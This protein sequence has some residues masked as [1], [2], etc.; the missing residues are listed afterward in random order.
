LAEYGY[1]TYLMDGASG[2]VSK[3][4]FQANLG[5][6]VWPDEFGNSIVYLNDKYAP[7]VECGKPVIYLYPEKDM[8]VSV[9]VGAN[10][11]KSE[12]IYAG[13]WS[14]LARKNGEL[15]LNGTT[16]PYLFWEGKGLGV[17]P[18]IKN[19]T[20]VKQ[21]ETASTI[22]KQLAEM[23]L[24]SK[25]IA[26]FNEFWLPKLPKAPFVRLTWL[27]NQEMNELAPL[28]VEPKPDS[29]LRVFLDFEGLNQSTSIPAQI[30]P[31]YE[32]KGFTLVEWG[33]LLKGDR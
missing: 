32:R 11:R 26:D 2:K 15:V 24:N 22:A 19:G 21:S 9:K 28:Q 3:S 29:V 17:Y 7:A 1:Q 33:G 4:D 30:L 20:V 14:V 23:G 31:K 12:P 16:Y 18:N 8:R 13:G 25:E 5:L 27:T 6:L 10:V